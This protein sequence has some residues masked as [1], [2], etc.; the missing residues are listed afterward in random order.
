MGKLTA[1]DSATL[2]HYGPRFDGWPLFADDRETQW[3]PACCKKWYVYAIQNVCDCYSDPLPESARD[4]VA[5]ARSAAPRC[6][7][8]KALLSAARDGFANCGCRTDPAGRNALNDQ[9]ASG[10]E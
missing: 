7:H 1:N 4:V 8:C 6:F 2:W 5:E 3:R 10:G 9:P